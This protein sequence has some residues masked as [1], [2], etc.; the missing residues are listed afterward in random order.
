MLKNYKYYL[1]NLDCANCAKKVEDEIKKDDRFSSV[2]VNFSTLTLSFKTDI[3]D[4][5][6]EIFKIVKTVEPD[7][8]VYVEKNDDEKSDYEL[9]RFILALVILG[10]SFLMDVALIKEILIVI[11]YLLLMYKTMIKAIKKIVK[12]HNVDENALICISA[13]GAYILGEHMEGLMVLLLYV[14][15]K[16]LEDKAVNKSRNSIKDLV[17]L[18][19]SYANL[20][21]N[22]RINKVKSES[23]K[24][25]DIIVVKKGEIIPVDGVILQG[26]TLV[27]ASGLTGEAALR[28]IYEKEEVLSG[29]IN[30]GEV[31]EVRVEKTY[32]DSTAYKILELTLNATNNKAKT[33]TFVSKIASYYTPIVLIIA[34]LIGAFLPLVSHVSYEDSIYR[35]LTFLVI[36]CPCAIAISVP[37]SYFAGIGMSSKKKILVKGSNYLDALTKCDAIVF[38][39]TGTLTTGAFELREICV[40]DEAYTKEEI[41]KLASR[42]EA[43]STHPIARII[44]GDDKENF[45]TS[46]VKDFQEID[47][48]GI[49]FIYQEDHIKVGSAN[50]CKTK[51]DANVFVSVNDRVIGGFVFDDHIKE[52]ASSVVSSLKNYGIKTYMFTGD[53]ASFA[54]IVAENTGIDEYKA[55]M[56]PQEK[57]KELEDLQKHHQV[58][59]VGDGI[60]D[61]PSLVEADVGISMGS[62]GSNSAIEASDIVIMNDDLEGIPTMLH[63]AH[64]TKRIIMMN[65]IFSIGIKLL[66]LVLAMFGI[67]HM[68]AAVFADT[69]VT[70]LAILNSLRILKD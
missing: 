22:K 2:I 9:L 55:E 34:I 17:E 67:A 44:L 31:I 23:L 36:S 7:V 1:D 56:L 50:F 15:G 52:N 45:D 33:E 3:R 30:Q 49:E 4:P 39:K 18:K 62:I 61:A 57:F 40:Y 66:I 47:G 58:M 29:Y 16:I 19:A 10:I 59:F 27:D 28:E 12:S 35:A 60:N 24:I 14:L 43:F 26:H 53:N 48:K 63:I 11:S 70:L 38:D 65:L 8:L 32:Y 51:R 42:G 21:I 41:L 5:F 37:L 25:G 69:G 68:A 13:I 54:K 6:K 20:K 46:E 64:K